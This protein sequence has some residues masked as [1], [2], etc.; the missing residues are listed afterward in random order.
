MEAEDRQGEYQHQGISRLY[1][2]LL[3]FWWQDFTLGWRRAMVTAAGQGSSPLR[4][5]MDFARLQV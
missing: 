3:H 2:T 5:K 4:L 1:L